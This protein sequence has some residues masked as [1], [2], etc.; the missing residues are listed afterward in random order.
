MNA[1]KFRPP[2]MP[3]MQQSH[4]AEGFCYRLVF[5]F[6]AFQRVFLQSR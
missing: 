2:E 3:C 4:P 5:A 6:S 1:E